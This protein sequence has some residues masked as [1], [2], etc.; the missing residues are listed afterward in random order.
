MTQILSTSFSEEKAAKRL[1]LL[2]AWGVC[3]ITPM[4]QSNRSFL[5]LFFKKEPLGLI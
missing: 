5:L 3:S 2:R 4:A 1:L